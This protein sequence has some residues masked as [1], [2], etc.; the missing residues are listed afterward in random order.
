MRHTQGL[1]IDLYWTSYDGI[2]RRITLDS[3]TFTFI[4][5]TGTKNIYLDFV[6]NCFDI[7]VS[8]TRVYTSI[9]LFCKNVH[10]DF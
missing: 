6:Q 2:D 10:P 9:S 7:Y 8:P 4:V 5:S 1:P 3:E